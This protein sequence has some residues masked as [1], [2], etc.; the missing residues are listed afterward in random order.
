MRLFIAIG[1]SEEN[2]SKLYGLTQRLRAQALQGNTTK[3]ENLHLTLAFIGEVPNTTYKKTCAV[4]DVLQSAPFEVTFDRLGKFSQPD[5]A[6]YW[7][8]SG[9]NGALEKLQRQ[10]LAAL[11]QNHIPVDEKPFKPHITLGRR[12][13]MEEGFSEIDFSGH[14]EPVCQ[15]VNRVSLMKSE[16]I[17]GKLVYTE[18]Y[19]KR[20]GK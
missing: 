8:G 17:G 15:Q 2:K 12:M 4:L 7:L 6:L 11:K 9:R 16:R 10:L 3:K 5:G 19:G 13:V 1:F 18:V 14:I 20:L